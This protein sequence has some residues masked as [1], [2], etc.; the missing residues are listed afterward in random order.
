M[1]TLAL[2]TALLGTGCKKKDAPVSAAKGSGSAVV[3]SGNPLRR[4]LAARLQAPAAARDA[5]RPLHVLV[6][7]GSLGAVAVND[8]AA[9][10]LSALAGERPLTITHQAG[11]VGL[12]ATIKRYADAGVAATVSAFIT[13]M[14]SAYAAADLIIARAGA[15]TVAELALAGKPAIFI[16]Y[17]FAADNHQEL[18]ARE[19]AAAGAALSLRQ[20]DLTPA[21]L[22]DAL[23]PLLADDAARARMG[24]AMRTLARPD[25]A[26][27][28][29][30]WVL[31]PR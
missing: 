12:D 30:D 22:A 3:A 17:P 23:R 28:V 19:M 2:A 5:T 25:A 15:T 18:N 24:A 7:G 27:T 21:L 29:V 16:P 13:D 31:A 10:A 20:A 9:Q 11:K 26:A 1:M 6:C 14:A 4:D 8:L